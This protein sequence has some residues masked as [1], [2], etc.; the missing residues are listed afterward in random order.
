M[1]KVKH[2]IDVSWAQKGIDWSAVATSGRVDGALIRVGYTRYN[3]SLK[4]D[5]YFRQ[6]IEGAKAVGI[7]VGV[8]LYLYNQTP[9]GGVKGVQEAIQLVKEY[10]LN[11]PFAV[12]IEAEY[13]NGKAVTPYQNYSKAQNT[14]IVK[15]MLGEVEKAGFYSMLYTYTDFANNHLNMGE[16]SKYDLWIAQYH[17]HVTYKGPYSI[18]Q[19]TSLGK[20]PGISAHTV[21]LNH[22]YK[23]FAALIAQ[24]QLTGQPS[25]PKPDAPELP[26]G[27]AGS[28]PEL[29]LEYER[30]NAKYQEQKKTTAYFQELVVDL[31]AVIEQLQNQRSDLRKENENLKEQLAAGSGKEESAKLRAV[32]QKARDVLAEV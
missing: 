5:D 24:G 16:L 23:D 12:D 11:L 7:P 22:A 1:S 30:L 29:E 25:S 32:I 28:D 2:Y 14:E 27:G 19:Y 8:Y 17:S 10:G 3:G 20:I 31:E 15:A 26:A 13:R 6:N 18:W 9:Q 4:V 21:D